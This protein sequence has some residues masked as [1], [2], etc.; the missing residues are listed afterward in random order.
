MILHASLRDAGEL[1]SALGQGFE[2]DVVQLQRGDFAS[3]LL[4]LELPGVALTWGSLTR[5]IEIAGVARQQLNMLATRSCPRPLVLNGRTLEPENLVAAS[6]GREHRFVV[7]AAFE[8]L[9]IEF[10]DPIIGKASLPADLVLGQA[11]PLVTF[12]GTALRQAAFYR[13]EAS[14]RGLAARSIELLL[15]SLPVSEPDRSRSEWS[16]ARRRAALRAADLIHQNPREPLTLGL[17]CQHAHVSERTLRSGFAGEVH[18]WKGRQIG[19]GL[20]GQSPGLVVPLT[21]GRQSQRP[22]DRE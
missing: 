19:Q 7:P 13:S 4:R 1:K 10:S 8:G 5:T 9:V 17:L 2:I 18:T 20:E 15:R 21:Q 22:Q 12:A 16:G 11:R 6:H 3:R 14:R